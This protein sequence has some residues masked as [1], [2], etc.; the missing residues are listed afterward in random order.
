MDMLVE[1]LKGHIIEQLN[2]SDVDP[3]TITAD[4]PLFGEGGLGLDSI[5][6]LEV[7]VLLDRHY[8]I[9]VANPEVL[10]EYLRSLATLADFIKENQKSAAA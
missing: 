4:A 5:D 1:E 6:A 7:V 3:K 9:K 2:L 8:G 10:K